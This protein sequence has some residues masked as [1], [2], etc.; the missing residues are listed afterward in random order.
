ML[1]FSFDKKEMAEI[2]KMLTRLSPTDRNNVF[3]SA[4]R[5][6][7]MFI[8]KKLKENISGRFLNVRTGRL[9]SS[10][11][12]VVE[13]TK[14]GPVAKIGSGVRVGNRVKY[15]NILETGGTISAKSGGFLTIPTANALTPSGVVRFS[16]RDVFNG[17]TPYEGAVILNNMIFG[18]KSSKTKS[19]LTPLFTLKKSV[20][21]RASKYLSKTLEENAQKIL[22]TV[23]EEI[24]KA[25]KTA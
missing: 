25:V 10:I 20:Q 12:S 9:R 5:K 14:D 8:E 19:M 17:V 23:M 6:A 1:E 13:Q 7:A 2:N 3:L 22:Y 16:A 15:A 21:I 4:F 11:G 24:D 18:Y